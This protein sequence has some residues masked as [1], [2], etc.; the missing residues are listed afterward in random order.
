MPNG[1]DIVVIGASAG[2]VEPLLQVA[3]SLPADLSAAITAVIRRAFSDIAV[4]ASGA[5][6][7]TPAP[8]SA[9][10]GTRV[11][12]PSTTRSSRVPA[13]GGGTWA[14]AAVAASASDESSARPGHERNDGIAASSSTSAARIGGVMN[15]HD[16]A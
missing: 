3:R 4:L 15:L 10:S 7:T 1:H 8:I 14:T 6:V 11:D 5:W 12:V 2:G 16:R 13:I 9:T